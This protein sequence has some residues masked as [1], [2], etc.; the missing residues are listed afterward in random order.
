MACPCTFTPWLACARPS[1]VSLAPSL[2]LRTPQRQKSTRGTDFGGWCFC[3]ERRL[4]FLGATGGAAYDPC[5]G[6]PRGKRMANHPLGQTCA[7]LTAILWAYALVL[8]KRSGE[9]VAPVALNLFKNAIGMMLLGGTLGVAVLAGVESFTAVRGYCLGDVALVLLSGF[10][11][12]AL[13]DTLLFWALNLI[14]VGLI[15][16]ADCTYAP[17]AILFSWLLLSESLTVFHYVG[18]ALV[19]L[20]VF[21]S[22]RHA[23]SPDRTRGQIV[24]GVLLAITAIAVMAFGIVL[25]KPVL[26]DMSLLWAT[27]LRMSAGLVFLGL[28]ALLGADWR[29]HWHVFR[30]SR[31]WRSALPASVLGMYVCV[32]LWVAGFKYTY[33][34]VAALLNQTSVVFATVLAAL[35]LKEHFGRRQAVALTLA[36]TGVVVVSFGQAV[37]TWWV[38]A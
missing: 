21:I 22:S 25:A 28:F 30:P 2:G 34:S 7:L 36:M 26:E 4:P 17:L 6:D 8:F 13:A 18:A 23:P 24:I 12:I 37:W 33:A 35:I 1:R 10:L 3:G 29:R 38:R 5:P 15:S 9:Q 19:I 27:T 11:G 16:I 31:V 14:G 20:G 32:L